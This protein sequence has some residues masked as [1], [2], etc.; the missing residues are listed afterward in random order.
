MITGGGSVAY[1]SPTGTCHT[2]SSNNRLKYPNGLSKG[3]DGLI[4]VPSTADGTVKVFSLQ[5]DNTLKLQ[6]NIRTGIPLDNISPDAN[7]DLYA[8]AFPIALKTLKGMAD[9]YGETSPSTVIRIRKT[10]ASEFDGEARYVVE[11]VIEDKEGEI[12][13][14]ATTV[15]HDVKTGRLFIGGGYPLPCQK[16]SANVHSGGTSVFGGLR[17]EMRL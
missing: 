16:M 13:S 3:T 7:G 2:A 15:R 11:K 8:A 1:C 9:P 12:I 6:H 10:V 5:H 14:G 17:S 4:Y